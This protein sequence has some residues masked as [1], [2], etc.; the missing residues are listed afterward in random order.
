MRRL[1][2]Y[3][4]L[5]PMF[6]ATIQ[7]AGI[8]A[9]GSPARTSPNSRYFL[10]SNGQPCF[11]LGDTQWELFLKFTAEDARTLLENRRSKGFNTVQIMILGAGGGK[12]GNIFGAKPFLNDNPF[13]PNE[14]YFKLVDSIVKIAEQ[15][16]LVLVIGIYHKSPDYSTVINASNARAWGTWVGQRYQNNSNIIW[17]MY[18]TANNSYLPVIRELASG[19]AAGDRGRHMITV[20][21]D[22]APASS[23]WIHKEP[24]L[25]FNTLQTWS[26][27]FLNYEMV[28]TDYARTPPKPVVDG[29][30]RYEEEDGTSPLAVRNGAYWACL[31]GGF[32]SYGHG[33]NWQAPDKW[34]TWMDSPGARQMKVLGDFFRSFEWWNLEPD[35]TVISGIASDN[36]AA[37]SSN[38]DLAIV[39][40]PTASRVS[41]NMGKVKASDT[42][43][44]SW[45]NPS[46]GVTQAVGMYQA[47]GTQLFSRPAEWEDAVLVIRAKDTAPGSPGL[48]H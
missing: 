13:T 29:E 18:P 3:V 2:F 9:V 20:H 41:I 33:G 47:S 1:L 32:Y 35:Q 44:A 22:P 40:V 4:S 6:A 48:T 28:L 42:L 7:P 10:D 37:R 15:K 14:E 31:A 46:S 24:W 17:S 19:L 25:S 30:A 39:Y 38:K 21:P 8:G 12:R 45:M 5:I 23:S 16:G 36:A 26:S 27:S 43:M 34:R 11:W